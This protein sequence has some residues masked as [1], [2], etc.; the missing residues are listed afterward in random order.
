MNTIIELFDKEHLHNALA[1]CAAA[2][3][4]VVLVGTSS[5]VSQRTA[6]SYRRFLR[7]HGL[8]VSVVCCSVDTDSTAQ[9]LSAL[10]AI[11]SEHND[12]VIELTGGSEVALLAAGMF[13]ER[14]GTPIMRFDRRQR[15]FV[16]V[17]S[18]P[19][20]AKLELPDISVHD[21]FTVAG[22]HVVRNG[23]LSPESIGD[24]YSD[25]RALW[26]AFSRFRK[27]WHLST[28]FFKEA[29]YDKDRPLYVNTPKPDRRRAF[30]D[31]ELVNMLVEAGL[32]VNYK[33]SGAMVSFR[34]KDDN[35]R[36]ILRDKGAVLE[37]YTYV[38]LCESRLFDSCDINVI[39]EWGEGGQGGRTSNEL[40]CV[41]V[42]GITPYM[43]SCK[44]GKP[45]TEHL[46]EVYTVAREIAGEHSVPVLVSSWDNVEDNLPYIRQRAEDMGVI[47]ADY[48]DLC[49]GRLGSV[50][51]GRRS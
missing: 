7:A 24:T 8:D 17:H 4:T 20:A 16:N 10:E 12:C 18:C 30:L 34:Y 45:E 33:D 22:A 51:L 31:D 41:A 40:D 44:S 48:D 5:Q 28:T 1:A 11:R 35:I 39:V 29:Q 38:S 3:Q 13:A 42:R 37:L 43:I 9:M 36:S 19:E 6:D 27:T 32:L 25:S 21:I 15:R 47:L 14:T 26:E 46:N 23:R 49:S 2:P 50:L